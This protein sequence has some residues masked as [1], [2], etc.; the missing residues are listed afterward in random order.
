MRLISRLLYIYIY[1]HNTHIY[2][3]IVIY[4]I[5]NLLRTIKIKDRW[6]SKTIGKFLEHKKGYKMFS[7]YVKRE[8]CTLKYND[9]PH[10]YQ[11]D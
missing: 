3:V 6:S 7:K 11:N 10:I 9:I 5:Y 8:K 2:I 1:I 4:N